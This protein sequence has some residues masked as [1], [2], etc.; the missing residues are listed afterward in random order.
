MKKSG[1][2]NVDFFV[3]LQNGYNLV[4]RH[5]Y[6]WQN[7]LEDSGW[8]EFIHD[9]G[10]QTINGTLGVAEPVDSNHCATKGYVDALIARIE[11]LEAQ[12][13]S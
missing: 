13:N 3:R 8:R 7:S 12:L 5:F 10:G 11:A 2:F 6:N 9:Q 4:T 1:D